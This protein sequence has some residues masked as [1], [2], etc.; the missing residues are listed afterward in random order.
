MDQPMSRCGSGK[1][2]HQK[3]PQHVHSDDGQREIL[4][5]EQPEHSDTGQ[6]P[7]RGPHRSPKG[8]MQDVLEHAGLSR[9]ARTMSSMANPASHS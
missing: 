4:R 2:A 9:G 6:I 8:D 7:Q 1:H 3:R 5:P